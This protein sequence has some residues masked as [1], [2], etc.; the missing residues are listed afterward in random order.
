MTDEMTVQAQ[1][2]SV[3]PYVLGG[4]GVGAAAGGGLAKWGNIGIKG[5]AYSNWEDAVADANKDDKF[6][7][8]M[9]E[10]DGNDKTW[11][12]LKDE[13]DNMA[14]ARETYNKAV[15][16]QIRDEKVFTDYIEKAGKL[17]EATT[18]LEAKNNE[19]LQKAI[20]EIKKLDAYEV[21]EADG[22]I[23]KYAKPG[24]DGTLPDGTKNIQ[25]FF[26]NA[27]LLEKQAKKND[28]LY[29]NVINGEDFAKAEKQAVKD[30][31][32]AAKV[33]KK[34]L[35]DK[36]DDLN[37]NLTDKIKTDDAS[38]SKWVDEKKAFTEAAEKS[39][40]NLTDDILKQCKKPKVWL[41]ALAG[42]AALAVVGA[43]I[44]PKGDKA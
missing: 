29:N 31:D 9:A 7:K 24:A 35:T 8:E 43:L 17:T 41:T 11:K 4:A 33:A 1:R 26:D 27:D 14:S 20:D 40:K 6:I 38:I 37:K 13:I 22:K 44:A 2:P 23:T 18:N 16:E 28:A 21:T 15:P 12:V 10:K 32:E 5:Q 25:E 30:A 3:M 42:A 36:V 19:Q 39:K 34:A